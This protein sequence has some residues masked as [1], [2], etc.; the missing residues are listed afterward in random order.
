LISENENIKLYVEEVDTIEDD[1]EITG[2]VANF[3]E[4]STIAS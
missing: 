3:E 2:V 1:E 4:L